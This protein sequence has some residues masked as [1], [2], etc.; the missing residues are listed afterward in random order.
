MDQLKEAMNTSLG[1]MDNKADVR[2]QAPSGWVALVAPESE[3][4]IYS[5]MKIEEDVT[6][7]IEPMD[8]GEEVTTEIDPDAVSAQLY[9]TT[10][11]RLHIGQDA[12]PQRFNGAKKCHRLNHATKTGPTVVASP[13]QRARL[14]SKSQPGRRRSERTMK[15][16]KLSQ[17]HHLS[18]LVK[19]NLEAYFTENFEKAL[20]GWI[21]L[22]VKT[23]VPG[24]IMSIDSRFLGAFKLLDGAR[25][26]EDSTRSRFA[27]IRLLCLFESLEKVVSRDRRNGWLLARHSG[28]HDAAVATDIYM[29]AQDQPISRGEVKER[30]RVAR[31]WRIL[32]EPSPILVI[33]YSEA[34]E[35]IV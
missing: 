35:A 7:A 28:R 31:Y 2:M 33:I 24:N 23:E 16:Q 15:Q 21:S 34:A 1:N 14:A 26:G 27:Y 11:H 13:K 19:P 30:K 9:L 6:M 32:G 17:L 18:G 8:T 5:D 4:R 22:L 25:T 10:P 29:R 3:S 12:S 20:N